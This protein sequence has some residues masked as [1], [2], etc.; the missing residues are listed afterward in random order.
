MLCIS[1]Q[2]FLLWEKAQLDKGGDRS[3]L[4]L[5]L[6]SIAGASRDQLNSIR[7]NFNKNLVLNKNLDL[8][9]S[10]WDDHLINSVPIQ[11][12]CGLT[13]WRDLK[14]KVS[15]KVLIPRP[16]TELIVD[17]VINLLQQYNRKI[18][19]AELG[20]GSG[21]ISI[22][23]ALEKPHWQG[24]ATDIDKDALEIASCNFLNSSNQSNLKFCWGH[25]WQPLENL[26]DKFDFAIANP[27]YIPRDTYEKLPKEVKDFEPKI[28]LLGGDDGL[29]HIKEIVQN[30]PLHLKE[31]GW[32]IIENHF[33]QGS[34]VKKLFLENRFTCVDVLKDLSGIGRFTVGRYK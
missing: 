10:I 12:L 34:K 24:F 16:E 11:Y 32:L 27:P 2:E 22:S 5:L 33:D 7:I 14:L 1:A 9:E 18:I 20:T 15:E 19:F 6:E 31:K 17:I 4:N 28:A 8:I 29:V 3:S 13:F 25:W 21:A 23:L 26:K 30:A